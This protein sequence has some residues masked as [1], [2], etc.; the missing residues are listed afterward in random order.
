MRGS[1]YLFVLSLLMLSVTSLQAD[2]P[3]ILP[4]TR[5]DRESHAAVSAGR[6][7]LLYISRP[8][9]PY[10]AKL[11]AHVLR[12]MLRSHRFDN[13]IVLRELSWEGDRVTDFEGRRR[14]PSELVR[15]Y[16][17]T[18]TPTL[19]FLDAAG[20]EL[21]SR[22]VGYYSDDF[23]WYYFENAIRRAH[24]TLLSRY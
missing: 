14:D 18:G 23:Y 11:E 7:Y 21:T 8:E 13:Q 16:G 1:G 3:D 5:L 24:E 15:E 6:V 20:E 22:L 2:D 9:C 17:I 12:P 10:C 19:L 4:A